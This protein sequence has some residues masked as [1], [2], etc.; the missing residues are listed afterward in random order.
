MG[1]MVH[2]DEKW[3]HRFKGKEDFYVL[4]DEKTHT[5]LQKVRNT[6]GNYVSV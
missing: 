6:F 3:F 1:S 2:V 4:P 5:R